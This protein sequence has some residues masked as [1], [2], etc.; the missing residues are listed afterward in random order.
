MPKGTRSF[1][2]GFTYKNT[3]EITKITSKI[4]QLQRGVELQLKR[5]IKKK[6][7][8]ER[9]RERSLAKPRKEEHR[10]GSKTV[11]NHRKHEERK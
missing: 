9:E 2:S 6:K 11:K 4:A 10:N 5:Q 1:Q 7:K 8:K 3:Q